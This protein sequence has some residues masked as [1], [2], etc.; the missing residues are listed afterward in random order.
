MFNAD[1]H[2][3]NYL[4]PDMEAGRPV[5]FLDFGCVKRFPP[6]MLQTWTD[7]CRAVFEQDRERFRERVIALGFAPNPRSYDFD[8][9]WQMCV[10]L[11]RPWLASTPP[12]EWTHDYVRESFR[13]LIFDNP[14]KFKVNVPPDFVFANRLQWGLHSVLA[15]LAP[16]PADWRTRFLDLLYA[17]G[18]DRPAP[19]SV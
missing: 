18:A 13:W 7:L 8:A 17:E 16:P 6:E 2:P 5:V 14:N 4:F 1:P 9:H 10:Y 12:F 19:F 3:G 15:A 11:L